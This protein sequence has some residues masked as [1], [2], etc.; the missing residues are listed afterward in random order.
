MFLHGEE[1]VNKDTYKYLGMHFN[2]TA[3][4]HEAAARA[5]QPFLVEAYKVLEFVRS[6]A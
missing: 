6:H 2:K 4:L 3:N 5:L 1:L